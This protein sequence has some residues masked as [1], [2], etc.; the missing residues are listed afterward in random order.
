MQKGFKEIT[1][2]ELKENTL[3]NNTLN[4][5]LKEVLGIALCD[6]KD[7]IYKVIERNKTAENNKK[8]T[9]CTNPLGYDP[10]KFALLTL[11]REVND[12]S[13]KSVEKPLVGDLPP[14]Q[15]VSKEVHQAWQD[16][17]TKSMTGDF[18]PRPFDFNG[19]NKVHQ[20]KVKTVLDDMVG[21][22]DKGVKHNNGKPQISLLFK[23]FPK[24]LEAIA[25]CSEYG[26]EKYKE[27]DQDYLNYQ[28]VE[29]G[30]KAYADAG[31]R[32]RLEQG[33]DVESGLPHQFHVAWNSLAELELYIQENE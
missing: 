22:E 24:A 27:A 5:D 2:E 31:F 29:E 1:L 25:K 3:N 11:D 17:W 19:I 4:L 30:S 16:R 9:N 14:H 32:H 18:E 28:R 15:N 12:Y 10:S 13:V 7:Y 6:N 26:H 21:N 33:H 20:E 8:Q 23:Q